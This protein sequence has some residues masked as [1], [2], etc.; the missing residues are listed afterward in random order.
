MLA[1]YAAALG[2]DDPLANLEVGQVP[3][4]TPGPGW[5]LVRV[6]AAALNHHDLWTLRGVTAKPITPPV[7]LGCDAAGTVEAYGGDPPAGAPPPGARVVVHAVVTCGACIGCLSDEP[8]SCRRGGLLSEPPLGGTLAEHVTVP[9][10]NLIPLP[11]AVGF[12]EAACLPTAYLTA[13]HMLFQS[14]ALQPGMSVL[15]HGTAGGVST[16]AIL[17]AHAA[18]VTVYATS[19]DEAKRQSAL[20]LGV[21]AAFPPERETARALISATGGRG[22]DAVV[23]TVGEATWDLS[24]R[25][26]RPG[27]TVV[28]SGATTGVNP[29]AQLNRIFWFRITIAGS[30]MGSRGELRRLVHLCETGTLRPQIGAVHPMREVAAAFSEMARGEQYG[31]IVIDI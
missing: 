25:A 3:D 11:D 12:R 17:L 14:A 27:G 23:E 28:V 24:L 15:V 22:V 9:A 5:A 20:K 30:T 16:A 26:V 18:G 21:T 8:G 13:Y 31:K 10:G 7:V 19:R 2:G 1:A 6:H 4:P 29:P